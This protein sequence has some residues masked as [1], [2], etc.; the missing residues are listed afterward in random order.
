MIHVYMK[1]SDLELLNQNFNSELIY[2]Q[3]WISANSLSL[4]V[5]KTVYLLCSDR[6]KVLQEIPTFKSFSEKKLSVD[7]RLNFLDS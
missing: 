6:K 4:N 2:V 7:R 3:N 1:N 5:G